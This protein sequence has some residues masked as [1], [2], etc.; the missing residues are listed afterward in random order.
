MVTTWECP[1]LRVGYVH[2][3]L[4]LGGVCMICLIPSLCTPESVSVLVYVHR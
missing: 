3:G 4:S 2:V 1:W